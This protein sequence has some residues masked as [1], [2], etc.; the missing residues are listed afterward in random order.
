MVVSGETPLTVVELLGRR[1]PCTP[2]VSSSWCGSNKAF[3]EFMLYSERGSEM[4]LLIL[5]FGSVVGGGVEGCLE[6][7]ILEVIIRWAERPVVGV[8]G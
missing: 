8:G 1:N 3:L 6:V 2:F 4:D 5:I 7:L